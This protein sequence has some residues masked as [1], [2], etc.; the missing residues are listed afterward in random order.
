MFYL[1]PR[2]ENSHLQTK[3]RRSW[4]GL[5][6]K[7]PLEAAPPLSSTALENPWLG[8]T[9]GQY[10]LHDVCEGREQRLALVLNAVLGTQGLHQRGHLPVVV[11]WHGG[12]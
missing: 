11:P 1:E 4:S 12:E 2:G 10:S 6:Q 3:Q 8:N 9:V 5:G 7:G